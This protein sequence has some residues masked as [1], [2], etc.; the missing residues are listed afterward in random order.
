MFALVRENYRYFRVKSGQSVS[1]VERELEIPV[2]GGIFSGRILRADKKCRIYTVKVGDTYRSVCL[3][4]GVDE[5]TL[6]ELNSNAP[7]YPTK[8]LYIPL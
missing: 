5:E 1:D 8:K 7:L 6:K 4:E 3:K 2:S